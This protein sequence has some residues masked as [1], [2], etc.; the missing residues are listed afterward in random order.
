[1]LIDNDIKM[2]F[3][4]YINM[5]KMIEKIFHGLSAQRDKIY[6]PPKPGTENPERGLVSIM[7]LRLGS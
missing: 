6:I 1:M 2:D 3:A 5:L 4:M 7:E